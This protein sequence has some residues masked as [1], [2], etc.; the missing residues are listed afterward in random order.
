MKAFGSNVGNVPENYSLLRIRGSFPVFMMGEKQTNENICTVKCV[1]LKNRQHYEDL[2][3]E[4]IE[5]LLSFFKKVSLS[6]P[7]HLAC[8]SIT[9]K[10][11]DYVE[12]FQ[13]IDHRHSER[14]FY[15]FFI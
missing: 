12:S 7:Y 6:N 11:I 10:Y 1:C 15:F 9:L 2:K 13:N 4:N 14:S 8:Q 5:G 3:H